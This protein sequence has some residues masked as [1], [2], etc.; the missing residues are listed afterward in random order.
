MLNYQPAFLFGFNNP[1]SKLTASNKDSS[2]KKPNRL[3]F[4]CWKLAFNHFYKL[5]TL[6]QIS[7]K[8]S[9]AVAYRS[10][11]KEQSISIYSKLKYTIPSQLG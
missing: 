4:I 3:Y 7:K 2:F 11:L 10:I 8:L 5:Y 1:K 9:H 6:T